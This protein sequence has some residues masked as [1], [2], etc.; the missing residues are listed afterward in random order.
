MKWALT[1][2]LLF[3]S[4]WAF[5]QAPQELNFHSRFDQFQLKKSGKKFL[6][7]GRIAKLG[8]FEQL[9]PLF[10]STIE[11]E[12]PT[13]VKT[14]FTVSAKLG[15]K[16]VERQFDI[17]AAVVSDGKQC[18][19]ISGEGLVFSPLHRSW[20]DENAKMTVAL[21]SPF[22]ITRGEQTLV[23]MDKVN[24]QWR[25][26]QKET[27][28][29]WEFFASFEDSLR[30]F[31]IA[32]RLHRSAANGKPGFVMIS[33][34]RKFEFFKINTTMWAA[35]LP[36]QS[37]L[38]SSPR[39]SQW[40][41]MDP[42]QWADRNGEILSVLADNERPLEERKAALSAI[43]GQWSPS[44][45]YVLAQILLD[46]E[47]SAELKYDAVSLM[48]NKPTM[49]NM[50]TFVKALSLSEDSDLLYALTQALRIRN[51]KGELINVDLEAGARQKVITQW[52]K[53]W[54]E[55]KNSDK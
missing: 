33:G 24:G 20:F 28:P 1:C 15:E 36:G 41:D 7:A 47:E 4:H 23:A 25:S 22:K 11:G 17:E 27:F 32:H 49:E 52:Q 45:R 48:R 37:W 16:M 8:P 51:P 9:L 5:A 50:G 26:R 13:K 2:Y 40:N 29:S 55:Q 53:W 3:I 6:L 42:S 19:S 30:E 46:R 43:G 31:T 12:C 10:S 54:K 18:A 21:E 38:V 14:D 34:N 44:I 35:L 39:W